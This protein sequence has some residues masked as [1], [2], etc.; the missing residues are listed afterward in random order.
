MESNPNLRILDQ[1]TCID[2]DLPDGITYT[3]ARYEGSWK[4]HLVIIKKGPDSSY[5]KHNIGYGWTDIYNDYLLKGEIDVSDKNNIKDAYIKFLQSHW[6]IG[7]KSRKDNKDYISLLS[8]ITDLMEYL[9]PN[10]H[11]DN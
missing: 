11:N 7:I 5:I 4:E 8:C 3:I 10:I 2:F 6:N 1:T 9:F